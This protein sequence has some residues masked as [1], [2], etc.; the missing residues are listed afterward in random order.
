M[1]YLS[2][3]SRYKSLSPSPKLLTDV[4]RRAFSYDLPIYQCDLS[5]ADTGERDEHGV[6]QSCPIHI[7]GKRYDKGIGIGTPFALT[8][9]LDG[10]YASF[11][12]LV[13]VDD[14]EQQPADWVLQV[15]LD[16]VQAGTWPIPKGEA[17]TVQVDT[18][19]ARELVLVGAGRDRM[20]VDLAEA[21]LIETEESARPGEVSSTHRAT[22]FDLDDRLVIDS[23]VLLLGRTGKKIDAETGPDETAES[24]GGYGR[25]TS[26]QGADMWAGIKDKGDLLRWEAL[27]RRP[28]QYRL[29]VRVVSASPGQP[30]TPADYSVRVDGRCL[31]CQTSRETIVEHMPDE[32]FTGHLWGYIHA[33]L[34]LEVGLHDVEVANAGGAWLAVNRV[35]LVP[36][37]PVGVSLPAGPALQPL[38]AGGDIAIPSRWAPRKLLGRHFISADRGE[39]FARPREL[40]LTFAPTLTGLGAEFANADDESIKQMLASGLPFTIHAR[41]SEPS[42]GEGGM[43][44]APIDRQSY[45]RIRSLAGDLWLGFWTTEW[46][47]C[48]NYCDEAKDM[49]DTREGCYEKVKA[50]YQRKAA[51]CYD[52]VLAMC[53]TR[54]WDH[55]AGEWSGGS[56]FEDE[57]GISPE[58]QSNMLFARGAARQYERYWH[59]Y[60]AP[61]AHDAHSWLVNYYLIGRGPHDTRRNAEAGGSVSW[62]KRMMYVSYM[63]GTTSLKNE[64]PAYETDMTDDGSVGLSPMGQVADEFFAFVA[65]HADRG[66]NYTP[67]GLMLDLMHGW[68]TRCIYPD[69]IPPLTWGCLQPEPSDYMKE[70]LF[71]VIYPGQN[72]VLNECN[73]LSPTPYGDL[74]DVMLST[75]TPEHVR[76][77]PVLMLLGDLAADMNERLASL[78]D[79]YV[80]GGGTLVLNVAQLT[81]ALDEAILGLRVTD[82]TRQADAAECHLDG[83]QLKGGV[84]D[85]RVVE[86]DGAEAVM[87]TPAGDP[88]VTRHNV[89]DGVVLVTT[90]P[91]LLQQNL[92]GV[93]FLPHLLEH[94]TAGLLPFRVAGDVEYAVNRNDD[95][96]L[97]T[98]VNNRGI[99][100]LPTDPTLIDPR[101]TQTAL[102]TMPA[103]PKAVADWITGE[104]LTPEKSGQDWQLAVD[105]PPG[106]LSIVQVR[107]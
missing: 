39:P 106:D 7:Q 33:D 2:D 22:M 48:F 1:I 21:S 82:Q 11:S 15:Y 24:L 67:V 38:A 93:C 78:L 20:M 23:E 45:D 59:S 83:R 42:M 18:A 40:G 50:W 98:L 3:V 34:P 47:D 55:Y 80:R 86:L 32:R 30:P 79:T 96:W 27:V 57:P 26:S 73:L 12:A 44:G 105:I 72:D 85:V 17:V 41:F 100:K 70:T 29:W 66:T 13:A 25:T 62:V 75:A 51:G 54:H 52:D 9:R 101:Q 107:M 14:A 56:G 69:S 46:S 71:Q 16:D 74:F 97:I 8:Y 89:G 99:Y 81:P 28:G 92:N 64:S 5:V 61:G 43:G 49:P 35:V 6:R 19:G 53:T 102:I 10:A 68:G 58:C 77:Y 91:F 104:P 84:F 4:K 60:I 36:Q 63:W 103:E 76:D 95:S 37:G 88:L 87:S 94:L 31:D 90:V 65:T